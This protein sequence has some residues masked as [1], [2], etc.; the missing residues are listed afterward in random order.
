MAARAEAACLPG[1]AAQG[2]LGEHVL[3][4]SREDWGAGSCS[5]EDWGEG[6]PTLSLALTLTLTLTL[7]LHLPFTLPLPLPLPLTSAGAPAASA[8]RTRGAWCGVVVATMT[9][10]TASSRSAW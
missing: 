4:C 7:P 2:L 6:S 3:A 10:E 5:G 9:Q 1:L 8:A